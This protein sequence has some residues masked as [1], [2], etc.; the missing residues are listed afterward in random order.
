VLKS[1]IAIMTAV[2]FLAVPELVLCDQHLVTKAATQERLG[3]AAAQREQDVRMLQGVLS[4]P[5]ATTAA[6][7][8]GVS[9]DRT[10]AALPTLSD[11]ELRD[12]AARASALGADP[13]SGHGD[14]GDYMVH[15]FMMI[16]LVV[17]LVAA[18]IAIADR[19]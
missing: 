12:L 15:D 8:L 4:T 9:I 7:K 14:Y 17:I 13:V 6:S 16:L 19:Y 5:Q 1:L 10:R 18:A 3:Q 11:L 2:A